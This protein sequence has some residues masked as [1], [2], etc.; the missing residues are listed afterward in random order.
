MEKRVRGVDNVY[1]IDPREFN[2]GN[3]GVLHRIVNMPG[4]LYK[5]YKNRISDKGSIDAIIDIAAIGKRV[6]ID[7]AQELG[8][9]PESSV[10]WPVDYVLSSSQ[11]GMDGVVIP[12]LP[13]RYFTDEDMPRVLSRLILPRGNPPQALS[14]VMLLI[15]LAEV[16]QWL[17][18][19]DLVF[20]DLSNEN[21]VW[22]DS[23][24]PSVVLIDSDGVRSTSSAPTIGA[25]G[26]DGW[27]DP[28]VEQNQVKRQDLYSDRY[29]LALAMYRGLFLNKGWIGSARKVNLQQ[30]P[31]GIDPRVRRLLTR[32]LERPLEGASR[33]SA[34]E[35]V[36]ALAGALY[37]R[38]GFDASAL[39]VLDDH[40]EKNRQVELAERARRATNQSG[41]NTGRFTVASSAQPATL[42]QPSSAFPNPM[43]YQPPPPPL[44]PPAPPPSPSPSNAYHP[45]SNPPKKK[46]RFDVGAKIG[47]ALGTALSI[48]VVALLIVSVSTIMDRSSTT[49]EPGVA[50]NPDIAVGGRSISNLQCEG[51]WVLV[52]KSAVDRGRYVS[53]ISPLFQQ[54]PAAKYLRTD[55][56][57]S[58]FTRTSPT[59]GGPIYAV[60]LGPYTSAA[61]ALSGCGSAPVD[62]YARRLVPERNESTVR[63]CRD[64]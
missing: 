17:E 41:N 32:S 60:Y 61:S 62:A 16:F 18:A 3:Y 54:F 35:W 6:F 42:G 51:S 46:P 21:A 20:G 24:E 50:Q 57:C 5:E 1:T 2:S 63:Y 29:A 7:E 47:L 45:A 15:R 8:S 58:G 38:G 59:D 40:A 4:Y 27:R 53:D 52:L 49:G 37:G 19:N 48:W 56:S 11:M 34:R 33:A 10:C 26:T 44:P 36:E 12:L 39:K 64:R 43:Q 22:S 31:D 25:S 13:A 23:A 55:R 9:R 28:R 14:R 30:I